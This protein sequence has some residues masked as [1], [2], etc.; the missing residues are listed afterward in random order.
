[1]K[2]LMLILLALPTHLLGQVNQYSD[3][4]ETEQTEIKGKLLY[5]IGSDVPFTGVNLST[6]S[7][8]FAGYITYYNDGI[9]D[10]SRVTEWDLLTN[11]EGQVTGKLV[12]YK[13]LKGNAWETTGQTEYNSVGKKLSHYDYENNIKTYYYENG[14]IKEEIGHGINNSYHRFW[15]IDGNEIIP[16]I[17]EAKDS[18]PLHETLHINISNYAFKGYFLLLIATIG[19]ILFKL[20][21]VEKPPQIKI[22]I[23]IVLSLVALIITFSI[24]NYINNNLSYERAGIWGTA[25]GS[26][27]SV[28]FIFPYLIQIIALGIGAFG[29][30]K[31]LK[32]K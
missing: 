12:A 1:M 14:N 3:T 7:H 30:S 20:K 24:S 16:T 10:T 8:G 18:D 13:T 15:D 17:S 25:F 19:I 32:S 2:Y 29:I 27:Y 23:V 5:K 9:K 21:N 11:K 6:V 22:V 31:N 4:L 26:L 28:M